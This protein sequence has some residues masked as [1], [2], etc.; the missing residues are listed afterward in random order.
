MQSYYRTKDLTEATFLYAS[1][2][3]IAKCEEDSGR[4][5]FIFENGPSCEALAK[6]L[7]R[8]EAIVN[9]RDFVDSSRT[10]RDILHNR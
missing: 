3:K 5:C 8:R 10:L 9:V 1:H 7:W 2:M 6:S 4:V